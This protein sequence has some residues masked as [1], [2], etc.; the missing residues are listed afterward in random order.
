MSVTTTLTAVS[1]DIYTTANCKSTEDG[2]TPTLV[3][4][5][6]FN[7]S[8]NTHYIYYATAST[9]PAEAVCTFTDMPA[10]VGIDSVQIRWYA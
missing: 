3:A 1:P 9:S 8:G 10:A 6:A 2:N 5:A 7:Q 4:Y